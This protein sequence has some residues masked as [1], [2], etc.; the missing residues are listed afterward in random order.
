[1]NERM[2]NP[3]LFD[4]PGRPQQTALTSL[5]I[6]TQSSIDRHS[7]VTMKLGSSAQDLVGS[8]LEFPEFDPLVRPFLWSI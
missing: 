3:P 4:R 7:A 6:I 1:M 5:P 2:H 8:D